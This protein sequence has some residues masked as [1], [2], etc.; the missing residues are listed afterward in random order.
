MATT[1]EGVRASETVPS[2]K[3]TPNILMLHS[4]LSLARV[5]WGM[6]FSTYVLMF[7]FNALACLQ[8]NEWICFGGFVHCDKRVL[9]LV[10]GCNPMN[11]GWLIVLW[12]S[13]LLRKAHSSN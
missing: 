9:W 7:G 10:Y 11:V 5:C 3:R 1:I 13:L 6:A 4:S 12:F 8:L 2:T